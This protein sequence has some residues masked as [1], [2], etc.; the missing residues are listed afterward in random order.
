[1]PWLEGHL[2]KGQ[3][4]ACRSLCVTIRLGSGVGMSLGSLWDQDSCPQ[5]RLMCQSLCEG[6]TRCLWGGLGDT[7]RGLLSISSPGAET[8]G[9]ICAS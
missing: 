7:G 4:S 9:V 8:R 6:R 1:M 2:P 3:G 5:S